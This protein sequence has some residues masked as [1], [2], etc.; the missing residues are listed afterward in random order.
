MT[1][2]RFL[3]GRLAVVTGGGRGIGAAIADALADAGADVA[4]LG[5]S[6]DVL[7]ASAGALRERA[8]VRV[9]SHVCDVSDASSIALAFAAVREIGDAHI[10]VNNAGQAEASAYDGPLD[11]WHRLLAVNLTGPYLCARE[12]MPA[13]IGAGEGRVINIASTA[14]LKGGAKLSAYSASKHGVIGL[15]KSLALETARAGVTVNAVC[16]GY[17]DTAMADRAVAAIERTG[18]SPEEALRLITRPNPQ[19]RLV[20]TEEVANAV[21]WLCTRDA[22]AVTGQAIVVAGG[23]QV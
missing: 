20:R 13:M 10:L 9:T 17:T 12:V 15:T 14:G 7:E 19:G 6:S 16:P 8:G 5:R 22:R 3:A 1:G 23:E 18:R 21:L 11:V 4:L 2:E